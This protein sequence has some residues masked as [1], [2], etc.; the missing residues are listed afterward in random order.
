M[1][2]VFA[3]KIPSARTTPTPW[4]P[5]WFTPG[6]VKASVS[7]QWSNLRWL[8]G[9]FG[10]WSRSARCAPDEHIEDRR[11]DQHDEAEHEEAAPRAEIAPARHGVERQHAERRERQDPRLTDD[12]RRVALGEKHEGRDVDPFDEREEEGENDVLRKLPRGALRHDQRDEHAEERDERVLDDAAQ[13]RRLGELERRP[14]NRD[15]DAEKDQP[16]RPADERRALGTGSNL[17]GCCC[18]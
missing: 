5:N 13:E 7:N 12:P 18:V 8:P 1:I 16:V 11:N 4:L 3:L 10:L 6:C 14:E 17:G 15:D 2:E 9:R